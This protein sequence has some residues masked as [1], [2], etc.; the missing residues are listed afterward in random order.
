MAIL[1]LA[2]AAVCVLASVYGGYI[3]NSVEEASSRKWKPSSAD[4]IIELCKKI[5]KDHP[6]KHTATKLAKQLHQLSESGKEMSAEGERAMKKMEGIMK[7]MQN[8]RTTG[9]YYAAAIGAQLKLKAK[10]TNCATTRKV[11]DGI[12]FQSLSGK[13]NNLGN[14]EWGATNSPFRRFAP[15]DYGGQGFNAPTTTRFNRKLPGPRDISSQYHTEESRPDDDHSYFL[16]QWGQ[17]LDHDLTFTPEVEVECEEERVANSNPNCI[18]IGIRPDDPQFGKQAGKFS[19]DFIPFARSAPTYQLADSYKMKRLGFSRYL[20]REQFNQLSA[21]ID[22]SNVYGSDEERME[23]LRDKTDPALLLTSPDGQGKPLLPFDFQKNTEPDCMGSVCFC[24][25]AGDVRAAEQ[26]FLTIVHGLF[27]REHN[28]IV[29]I[30]RRLNPKWTANRLFFETR[31]IIKS[32]FQHIVYDEYLPNLMGS[33]IFGCLVG[34]Y[35]GYNR[36]VNPGIFNEFA[37][38][39]FRLGHSQL[40]TNLAR[41]GENYQTKSQILFREGFFQPNR[42]YDDKPDGTVDNYVR[43]L[44]ARASQQIDRFVSDELVNHLFEEVD[45]EGT[46]QKPGI[47]LAALNIQRGRDHGLPGYFAVRESVYLALRKAGIKARTPFIDY[48]KQKLLQNV[49]GSIKTI[50]LWVGGLSETSLEMSLPRSKQDGGQLGPTFAVILAKQFRNTRDGDRFFWLNQHI[51]PT[52]RL[53]RPVLTAAQREAIRNTNLATYLCNNVD[54]PA[55]MK[56]QP[57]AF[58]LPQK[59]RNQRIS[60]AKIPCLDLSPWGPAI[61]QS[62]TDRWNSYLCNLKKKL[63]FC[64]YVGKLCRKTCG[65]CR[66]LSKRADG[67]ICHLSDISG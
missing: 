20:R 35:R 22:A 33:Y 47:D 9:R 26:P 18:S 55:T 49:Y 19:R 21:T 37:A 23:R 36:N 40:L 7:E 34:K 11:I 27:V 57:S 32:E 64:R 50:D 8:R 5:S 42:I 59:Y 43:G 52:K 65:V 31:N 30:L 1:H 41:V 24:P 16:M 46:P 66:S 12:E 48:R 54:N 4:D 14:P 39:V 6:I 45:R 60:C 38:A 63:G 28:R 67:K 25:I 10:K 15:T 13:C 56:V 58:R 2:A 53:S 51:D 44:L 17:F 3:P 29:A 61:Q 62:C